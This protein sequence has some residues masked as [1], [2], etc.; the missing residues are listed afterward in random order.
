MDTEDRMDGYF[1]GPAAFDPIFVPPKKRGWL[2]ALVLIVG[3]A[4]FAGAADNRLPP[5]QP[6]LDGMQDGPTPGDPIGLKED[7]VDLDPSPALDAIPGWM[8]TCGDCSCDDYNACVTACETQAQRSG[9]IMLPP[10]CRY[11]IVTG[12]LLAPACTCN[13]YDPIPPSPANYQGPFHPAPCLV[14]F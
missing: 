6:K 2:I 7:R 9:R 13:E 5:A 1:S 8:A 4:R 12:G 3:C 14:C 10:S 11:R